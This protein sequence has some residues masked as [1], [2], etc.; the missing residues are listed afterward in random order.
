MYLLN[1]KVTSTVVM[2]MILKRILR[3]WKDWDAYKHGIIDKNG[4]RL[5][6]P[7]NSREREGWD[8]LDRFCWTIKRL[9]TKYLGDSKF[10]YLFST[11][12][13]MKEKLAVPVLGNFQKYEPELHSF[14]TTK[15]LLLYQCIQELEKNTIVVESNLDLETNILKIVN[16][17]QPV[18]DKYLIEDDVVGTTV[19]D[20]AQYT[21]RL[22]INRRKLKRKGKLRRKP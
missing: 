6:R 12:Y 7:R 4:K 13:L 2:Y 19:G 3:D 9:C 8:I 5:R 15:Q 1:E 18:L 22:G 16:K 14:N 10:A 17:V 11:V 20:I 21:P